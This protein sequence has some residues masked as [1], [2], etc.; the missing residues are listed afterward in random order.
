MRKR[1]KRSKTA[2]PGVDG[3]MLDG[4]HRPGLPGDSRQLLGRSTAGVDVHG[5]DGPA[6]IGQAGDAVG[7]V[8]A[9]GERQGDGFHA[10][11]ICNMHSKAQGGGRA[12]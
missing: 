11:Y 12:A 8:E 7:R 3:V 1:T 5:M 2:L 4:A 9:P 10:E 6:L